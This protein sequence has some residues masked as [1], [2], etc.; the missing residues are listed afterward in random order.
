LISSLDLFGDRVFA[1]SLRQKENDLVAGRIIYL[2]EG[3]V[4]TRGDLLGGLQEKSC[5]E[6]GGEF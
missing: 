5:R 1:C 2:R 4:S 3:R 6:D